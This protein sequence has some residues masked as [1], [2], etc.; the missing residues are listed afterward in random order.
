MRGSL[1]RVMDMER[2][3]FMGLQCNF[4]FQNM[5]IFIYI[6]TYIYVYICICMYVYMYMY[7]SYA[8]RFY[9]MFLN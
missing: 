6:Y 9:L 1:D 3:D 8:L 2:R 4:F 5:F 7:I